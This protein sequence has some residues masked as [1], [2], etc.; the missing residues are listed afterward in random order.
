M[1]RLTVESNKGNVSDTAAFAARMY[2]KSG[3]YLTDY[4]TPPVRTVKGTTM[5]THRYTAFKQGCVQVVGPK[6]K[7]P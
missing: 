3:S 5:T 7:L 4:N 6:G 2:A 1:R